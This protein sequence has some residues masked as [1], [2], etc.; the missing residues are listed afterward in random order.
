MNKI[1]DLE[2]YRTHALRQRCF[3]AWEKRFNEK[4]S[5]SDRLA[6]ISDQSLYRLACPGDDSNQA[7]YEVIMGTLELGPAARFGYL[8]DDD[9]L[10]VV[11][12]HLFLVD[13]IRFELMRR[14]GW[15]CRYAAFNERIVELV[16]RSE[17]MKDRCQNQGP[18]LVS[19]HPKYDEY[20]KLIPR[21][22][23]AFVRSLL[24]DALE[25]FKRRV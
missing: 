10:R 16:H 2:R 3:G 15:I 14:L 5:L 22:K 7:F 24:T 18:K 9:K 4:Y 21:D 8:E 17:N 13:M 20:C 19:T 25:A 12:I 11:N 6:D 1:V 23:D